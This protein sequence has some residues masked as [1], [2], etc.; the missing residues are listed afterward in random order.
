MIIRKAK[1]ARHLLENPPMPVGTIQPTINLMCQGLNFVEDGSFNHDVLA[2]F[3]LRIIVWE[4][5]DT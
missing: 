1:A 3:D 5:A 4:G 2:A